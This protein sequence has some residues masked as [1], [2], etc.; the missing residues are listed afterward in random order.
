MKEDRWPSGPQRGV[1]PTKRFGILRQ[2]RI[3]TVLNIVIRI[4]CWTAVA[5]LVWNHALSSY[6]NAGRIG[7]AMALVFGTFL[8]ATSRIMEDPEP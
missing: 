8:H 5:W 4:S 6:F 7:P 2:S 1:F 3:G